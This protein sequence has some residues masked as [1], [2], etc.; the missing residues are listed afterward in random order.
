MAKSTFKFFVSISLRSVIPFKNAFA[1]Y[2]KHRPEKPEKKQNTMKVF[3]RDN[4]LKQIVFWIRIVYTKE[5]NHLIAES[6]TACSISKLRLRVL[7]LKKNATVSVFSRA[8]ITVRAT[9]IAELATKNYPK[10]QFESNRLTHNA[11]TLINRYMI[12]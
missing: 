3:L 2:S 4:L 1:F 12:N 5:R 7:V 10:I 11:Q 6:A 8:A 9:I